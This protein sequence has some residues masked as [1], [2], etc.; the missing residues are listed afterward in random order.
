MTHA[1][2]VDLA[3]KWLRSCYGCGIILS[4]QSCASGEQPDVIGW[5]KKC[6]SVVVECKVSRAD[7]LAD[8]EK[9]FR[10]HPAIAM[11]AERFYMAPAGLLRPEELPP[12]WGLLQ[13]RNR[14]VKVA[15]RC[16]PRRDLRSL[17]GLRNEL[18]LLLASLARVEL[19][20]EPQTITDFLKWENRMARYNGGRLP[21]GIT[22]AENVYLMP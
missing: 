9:P 6:R 3:V 5:K 2:L 21:Q 13:V 11:G 20:I 14:E 1:A 10:R 16:N 17:E 7:F 22:V 4:E 8:Q 18:N 12:G 15:V 19:R